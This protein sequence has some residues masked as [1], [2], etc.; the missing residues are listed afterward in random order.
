MADGAVVGHI[1]KFFPVLDR[2]AASG[3]FFVKKS[4]NQ[5]R[6]RQDLVARAVKQVGARHVGGAHRF[7]LAAA[8]AVL[9]A[10]GNITNVRL[11]HDQ[12]LMAHQP[13]AG[14]VGIGQISREGGVAQQLALVE[15]ALGVHSVFVVGKRL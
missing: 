14:C 12:R 15:A 5:Q 10:V 6:G 13:E 4:L 11:L 1:L 2:N 7:A 8:Q 3:L 9:D